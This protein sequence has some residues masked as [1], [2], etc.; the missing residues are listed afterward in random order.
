MLSRVA[1]Y[2]YWLGRYVERAE[3][4]ARLLDVAYHLELDAAA[5]DQ[6]LDAAP[7]LEGVLAILACRKAFEESQKNRPSRRHPRDQVLSFLTFDR[8]GK[9]S[10]L[11]MLAQARE[12]A[13][14]SREAISGDAWDQLNTLYL[15]LRTRKARAAL[16]E[17]PLRFLDR[18]KRGCNLFSGLIDSTM[19]R[20]EAYH[21]IQLGRHLERVNQ[22]GRILQIKLPPLSDRPDQDVASDPLGMVHWS[23]LLRSCSANEAYLRE[24]SD[25]VDPA[26]VVGFLLL[27]AAFPRAVRY[28]VDR[29]CESLRDLGTAAAAGEDADS[30]EAARRLGRLQ[31]ELRYL[32]IDEL[33]DRDLPRLLQDIQA[34][35]NRIGEEIHQT[36]FFV[37]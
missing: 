14:G 16:A 19:P 17:S 31:S 12:N 9:H 4:V 30:S 6:S 13:R 23:N 32:H 15:S 29:C 8:V 1:E 26:G 34:S 25:Q 24:Y 36:Y 21:F 28:C 35:C 10:I 7:P 37:S 2:L 33:F 27:N 18:V 11:S 20:A 5:L 22:M 3:N